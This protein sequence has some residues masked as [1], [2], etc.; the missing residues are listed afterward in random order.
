MRST[1]RR[2]PAGAARCACAD[3]PGAAPI[4]SRYCS[5]SAH[6]LLMHATPPSREALP[7]FPAPTRRPLQSVGGGS[8]RMHAHARRRARPPPCATADRPHP[9]APACASSLVPRAASAAA[10]MHARPPRAHRHGRG[11][12]APQPRPPPGLQGGEFTAHGARRA[13]AIDLSSSVHSHATAPSCT[14][15]ALLPMYTRVTP[16]QARGVCLL[17]WRPR[18]RAVPPQARSLWGA[19]RAAQFAASD[20]QWREPN[21]PQTLPDAIT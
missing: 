15:G 12:R 6:A 20:S 1:D 16:M 14:V 4:S 10:C 5:S 7:A 2:A 9:P 17:R 8:M 19:Q 13:C 21:A 18:L 3:C 11:R